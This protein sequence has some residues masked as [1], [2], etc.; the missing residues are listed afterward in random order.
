MCI[1]D[2]DYTASGTAVNLADRLCD[3]AEDG[4]ILVSPRA[5][6]ALEDTFSL[7]P[8]GAV[9]LKGMRAPVETMCLNG[10]A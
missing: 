6:I 4:E 3:E 2:S 9:E 1:R 5:A 10:P 8:R 7:S